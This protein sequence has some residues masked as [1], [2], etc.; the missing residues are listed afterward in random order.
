MDRSW[1]HKLHRD[2][3]KLTEVMDQM[4]L[5]DIYRTF[6]P[7]SKEYTFSA[8][9][10]T[11]SKI[12]H[13]ISYKTDLNRYNKIQIIPYLHQHNPLHKQTQ[14]KKTYMIISLDVEKAF[15]KI[16]HPF[17][18]KVLERPG[19]QGP[20]LNIVKAIYSKPIANINLKGE[21]L[22]AIPLKSGTRQG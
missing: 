2:T 13:I 1:K 22:E 17:M 20:Y 9:H 10:G 12:D 11:F 7:K 3:V 16:Q 21:K 15:N 18:V 4:D 5:T 6:H 8:P 14:R 19:I